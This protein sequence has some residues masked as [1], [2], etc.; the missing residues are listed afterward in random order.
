MTAAAR[1]AA[2]A[3]AL[4][5]GCAAD[6]HAAYPTAVNGQI[7]DVVT[8][9]NVKVLGDAPAMAMGQLFTTAADSTAVVN[10]TA[11]GPELNVD[12]Q[13]TTDQPVSVLYAVD[14]AATAVG[15]AAILRARC[16]TYLT[17]ALYA[18]CATEAAG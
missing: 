16:G 6:A 10:A 8:Q 4:L 7:T 15:I 9:A 14:T 13:A 17:A 12:A 2:L 3:C 1:L 18:T 5:L 11:A